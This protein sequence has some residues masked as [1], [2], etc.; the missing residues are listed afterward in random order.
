[1]TG[2]IHLAAHMAAAGLKQSELAQ[3]LNAHVEQLTGKSGNV[4]AQHIRNWRT[5]KT[6]WPQ[7]RLRL[8]LKAEFGVPILD[9]GF[10]PR[11]SG[12]TSE[13]GEPAPAPVR[14]HRRTQ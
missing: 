6:R 2:N 5:G 10:V 4:T 13:G 1:M 11:S 7:E 8:A 12:T 14:L 9:L 3:R